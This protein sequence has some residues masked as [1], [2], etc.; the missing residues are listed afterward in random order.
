MFNGLEIIGSLVV[1][2]TG[3]FDEAF[4]DLK[5]L[6]SEFVVVDVPTD[7]NL[8]KKERINNYNKIII[9]HM[10]RILLFLYPKLILMFSHTLNR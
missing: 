1:N 3:Q 7:D 5:S 4:N 10:H 6:C 9:L 2:G 8:K